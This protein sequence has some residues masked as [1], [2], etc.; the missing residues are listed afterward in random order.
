MRRDFPS[1]G[2]RGPVGTRRW[3]FAL[4]VVLAAPVVAGCQG[5][6]ADPAGDSEV[7][8]GAVDLVQAGVD[9]RTATTR[10]WVRFAP[11]NGPAA[12]V[13]W[14]VSTDG[15]T[16]PGYNIIMG[17]GQYVVYRDGT[18]SDPVCQGPEPDEPFDG[19]TELAIDTSCIAS[20]STGRPSRSLR[21]SASSHAPRYA[22]DHTGWT[23]EIVRS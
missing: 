22:Q 11:D 23:K 2:V 9:Y 21:I 3:W 20:P 17:S 19:T 5:T 16:I 12:F 8:D 6:V 13:V 10:L 14:N 4:L 1:S 18:S 15:D 7:I